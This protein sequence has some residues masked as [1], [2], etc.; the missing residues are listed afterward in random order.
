MESD[1][2]SV[3]CT[4]VLT[5]FSECY[6]AAAHPDFKIFFLAAAATIAVRQLLLFLI[7]FKGKNGGKNITLEYFCVI[8]LVVC[9]SGGSSGLG[10]I[11]CTHL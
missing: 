1:F 6:V 4:H 8:V 5:Y 11:S 7:F 2:L 9:N 10:L 3:D